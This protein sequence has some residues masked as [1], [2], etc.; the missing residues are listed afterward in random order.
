MRA[1]RLGALSLLLALATVTSRAQNS[2]QIFDPG[3]SSASF[4][5]H[6][7]FLPSPNGQFSV[8]TGELQDERAQQRVVV[9]VDGRS[10]TLDG[11]GWMTHVTRSDDFLAVDRYPEISFRSVAF[12]PALL[13]SGGVLSGQ[14]FLRGV[15]RDV[16]FQLLPS[17][18]TRPGRDCDIRVVGRISR[19]EF[20]MTAYRITVKDNVDFDFRVRLMTGAKP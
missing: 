8:V 20:G 10:L 1:A 19:R 2:R 16:A 12:A 14:L 17:I 15:R 11:P 5:V 3:R 18:C 7:R 6:M 9:A 13:R 4:R